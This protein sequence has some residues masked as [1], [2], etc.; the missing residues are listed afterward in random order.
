MTQYSVVLTGK[1][2]FALNFNQTDFHL[3]FLFRAIDDHPAMS[4]K[5]FGVCMG[6]LCSPPG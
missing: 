6:D 3:I 2:T 5:G 1:A 4:L